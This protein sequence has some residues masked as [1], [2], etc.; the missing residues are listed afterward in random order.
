MNPLLKTFFNTTIDS[1]AETFQAIVDAHRES[2]ALYHDLRSAP[3]KEYNEMHVTQASV[4]NAALVSHARAI[5]SDLQ[6][7]MAVHLAYSLV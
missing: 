5:A 1:Y 4:A 7:V 3:D 6:N 2:V